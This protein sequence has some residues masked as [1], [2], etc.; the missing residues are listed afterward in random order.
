MMFQSMCDLA[1]KGTL[2][3]LVAAT[4]DL[5]LRRSSAAARHR[6]WSLTM[7]GLLAMPLMVLVTPVI[8]TL[9][10]SPEV[11]AFVPSA[12][13]PQRSVN[14]ESHRP[15]PLAPISPS[16]SSPVSNSGGILPGM[17]EDSLSV[18]PLYAAAVEVE[19]QQDRLIDRNVIARIVP[20]IWA[21]GT[22]LVLFKLAAGTRRVACF[23]SSSSPVTDSAWHGLADEL[24]QRLGLKT[25]VELLEHPGD[26][27]P[28]TLGVMRPAIVLPRQAREWSDRLKRTVLLHELAH[29]RRRDVA[30]QWFGRLT[31]ALYWFHPLAW[32]GLRRLRQEREQA[33]D[34]LVIHCGERATE[35]AE[36]LVVVAKNFQDQCGLVCAVAMASHGSLEARIR[37]IFDADVI[38]SHAPLGR[39]LGLALILLIV[40]ST[41]GVS[42]VQLA[43]QSDDEPRRSDFAQT[44]E[45]VSPTSPTAN[46]EEAE[47]AIDDDQEYDEDGTPL[48]RKPGPLQHKVIVVDDEGKPVVGATVIPTGIGMEN[49]S[50]MGWLPNW[51]K[52]FTTNAH[53][54]A[55][56]LVTGNIRWYLPASR[57]SIDSV[58]F[59]VQHRDYALASKSHVYRWNR[60][61]VTLR[62]GVVVV[63][64]AVNAASNQPITS[65]LYAIS[66]GHPAPEWTFRD[67][68]LRSAPI[69]MTDSE[70][71]KYFRVIHAPAEPPNAP[72]LF[73]DVLDATTIEVKDHI[74]TI[75]VPLTAGVRL[76]GR[77]SNDVPRPLQKGG[78]VVASIK[79]GD[80]DL[81][82]HPSQQ[83]HWGDVAMIDENGNFEFS[84]L[85]RNSHVELIAVCDGW[86][87]KAKTEELAE[88]D[89]F[90]QTEFQELNKSE[91]A[92]STPVFVKTD[93]VTV[94]LNMI[95]MGQCEVLVEDENGKPLDLAQVR[96][97]PSQLTRGG[98]TSLG[99]GVRS[100]ERLQN[101]QSRLFRPATKW[102][103]QYLRATGSDGRAV[104]TNFPPGYDLFFVDYP[105]YDMPND[106]R[107]NFG[108]P[109]AVAEVNPGATSKIT[110]RMT[111]DPVY[112]DS[113]RTPMLDDEGTAR[114]MVWFVDNEG[115][116]L[117]GVRVSF[118]GQSLLQSGERQPWPAE[119]TTE[120]NSGE[121]TS[122]EAG[123]VFFRV[124]LPE[125]KTPDKS[126]KYSI[127]LNADCPGFA[128]LKNHEYSLTKPLPI[129]MTAQ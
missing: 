121:I 78:H 100:L 58:S 115:A 102:L 101:P 3:L 124:R 119:W 114:L 70:T 106:P 67:G 46:V 57:G 105:G 111:P 39:L 5:A 116:P 44:V 49:G 66:S 32:W 24:R 40:F 1:I 12:H 63:P 41:A 34:D 6:L 118:S 48:P 54:V 79:A 81:N 122:D 91:G 21:A 72:V 104:I 53:G 38:R 20:V 110:V 60:D 127:W 9:T 98:G 27:V 89:Q 126:P 61:P 17:T 26:V 68:E 19:P 71:G 50:S 95:Q 77:L 74:A 108:T 15:E 75:D 13:P 55:E 30:Y 103:S 64:R 47:E 92:A 76:S 128:P 28:L 96:F 42:A 65:D 25:V 62:H 36:D 94:T 93:D 11:A 45:P 14:F 84:A 7:I 107:M 87:S 29:V 4:I 43:A 113:I 109:V 117:E 23:R 22:L 125:I 10:V 80:P 33:C 35:Y 37:S 2:M 8:W 99:D 56:I 82:K 59:N 129:R 18:E 123:M 69:D 85:P 31:C 97:S 73:S 52:E 112:G 88:Y 51:P 86:M 83:V 90:H 16:P 120:L